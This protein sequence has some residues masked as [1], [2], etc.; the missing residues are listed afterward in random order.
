MWL[1]IIL[2]IL[3]ARCISESCIK[4]LEGLHRTFW[5]TTKKCENKNFQLIYYLRLGSGREGLNRSS[6]FET[7]VV[8]RFGTLDFLVSK[9]IKFTGGCKN[10]C[11]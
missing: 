3:P 10:I 1:G 11:F 7:D 4:G 8:A 6:G 9:A 2:E 5:G